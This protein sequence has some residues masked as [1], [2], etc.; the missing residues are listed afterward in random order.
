MITN[1]ILLVLVYAAQRVA[2]LPQQQILTSK[3]APKCVIVSMFQP[4]Q[5]SWTKEIDFPHTF[6]LPGLHPLY[7][8]FICTGDHSVCQVTTGEG[9]INAA[10]TIAF[11]ISNPQFDFRKTYWLFAGIAGGDPARITTGSV[12]FA[13]YA[14]QVGLS[15][16]ID[17]REVSEWDTGY[18]SYGTRQPHEYPDSVYGTEVFELNRNLRDRAMTLAS[19]TVLKVGDDENCKLRELYVGEVASGMP[20]VAACDVLTSDNYFTG[21]VL[22]DAFGKYAALITNGT[23]KYCAAAQEEN[24]SLEAMIRGAQV[25]TVDFGRVVVMRSISNFVRMPRGLNVSAVE[26]FNEFPK[27]GY[28]HA[29]RNLYVAGWPFVSDVVGRWTTLYEKGI[30]SEN[31]L[32]DILGTLGGV[33]DFGKDSYKIT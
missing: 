17:S 26:W 20:R 27:G 8:N 3:I 2:S 5:E 10:T 16:Q 33:R 13:Q 15:Y 25:G 29:L 23:A 4:E 9:E 11:L 7:P 14:V 28:E 22:N 32:G 1:L 30:Q 24:G 12:A 31:Y 21:A 19:H 6:Q 18:F